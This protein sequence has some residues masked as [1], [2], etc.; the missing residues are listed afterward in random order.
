M[1]FRNPVFSLE[2]AIFLVAQASVPIT[3]GNYAA[4]LAGLEVW[5]TA[6]FGM[7]PPQQA[8]LAATYPKNAPLLLS[9][10]TSMLYF[11]TALGSIVGGTASTYLG[12]GLIAW[13]GIPFL[14]L[15]FLTLRVQVETK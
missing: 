15:G 9:L 13:A 10:N 1:C 6:G 2:L 4:V 11:G 8:R 5:G 14:A 3:S 7:M 12:F